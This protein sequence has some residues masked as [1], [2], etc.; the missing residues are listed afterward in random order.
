MYNAIRVYLLLQSALSTDSN[1]NIRFT[2]DACAV[3]YE[4]P[5]VFR[6]RFSNNRPILNPIDLIDLEQDIFYRHT[7]SSQLAVRA[8]SADCY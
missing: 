7:S 3:Y 6:T 5:A 2:D 8:V 4:E 1:I